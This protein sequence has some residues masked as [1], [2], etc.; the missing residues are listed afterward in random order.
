MSER[1]VS[2]AENRCHELWRPGHH[3]NHADGGPGKTPVDRETAICRSLALVNMLPR[4]GATQL[5]IFLG[6]AK[7]GLAGGIVAGICF[8][9]PSFL[10]LQ[11]LM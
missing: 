3:G 7:G 6:H 11:P 5:G 1:S 2:L 4:P 9:L 10:S 8:I